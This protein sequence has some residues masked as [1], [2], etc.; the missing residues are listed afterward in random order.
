MNRV[1][2]QAE[3]GQ[4]SLRLSVAVPLYNEEENVPELLG[5]IGAVLDALPGGAHEMVFVDDGSS[6]RTLALL[7]G[8][9]DEEPEPSEWRRPAR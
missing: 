7:E 9:A 1:V 8:A 5:R 2:H 4:E 6:D 3:P